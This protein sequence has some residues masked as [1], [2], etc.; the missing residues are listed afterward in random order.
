MVVAVKLS[1][2]DLESAAS[3][4]ADSFRQFET[5]GHNS[6]SDMVQPLPGVLSILIVRRVELD[7]RPELL[8]RAALHGV[9]PDE[10]PPIGWSVV[11]RNLHAEGSLG[12]DHG[13]EMSAP[14]KS[15]AWGI[16]FP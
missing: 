9:I 15:T 16:F 4:H 12:V 5:S 2:T 1:R 7:L 3:R 6:R 8:H 14:P 10:V 11:G 13:H